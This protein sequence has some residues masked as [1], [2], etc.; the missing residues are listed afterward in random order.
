MRDEGASANPR[1]PTPQPQRTPRN[2]EEGRV[3]WLA[4]GLA[5]L[6]ADEGVRPYATKFF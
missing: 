6:G 5:S 3:L 2:T 4:G 1:F